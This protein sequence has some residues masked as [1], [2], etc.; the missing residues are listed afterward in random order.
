[1]IPNKFLNCGVEVGVFYQGKKALSSRLLQGFEI[2]GHD[3][4]RQKKNYL[5]LQY[6]SFKATCA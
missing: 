6:S 4:V 2:L 1:M 5:K 3:V